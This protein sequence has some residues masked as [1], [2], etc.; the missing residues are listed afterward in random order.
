MKNVQLCLLF[1]AENVNKQLSLSH[2]RAVFSSGHG[3][4]K[5]ILGGVQDDPECILPPPLL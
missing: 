2:L 3:T 5:S 1:N 4:Q